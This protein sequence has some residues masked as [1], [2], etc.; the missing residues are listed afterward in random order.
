MAKPSYTAPPNDPPVLGSPNFAA[1]AQGYLGWFPTFGA[2]CEALA[3]W[4]QTEYVAALASGSAALPALAFASDPNTGIFRPGADQLGFSTNGVRRLLLSAAAL[5]VDVPL[6]GIAVTQSNIDTTPGRLATVGW[7]GL[8]AN[9]PPDIPD[10][11][12]ELRPGFYT[13]SE[14]TAV[15]APGNGAAWGGTAIVAR[16]P[17]ASGHTMVIAT[18]MASGA[19]RTWIGVRGGLT[20]ALTWTELYHQRSVVGTVGQSAGV[21]TG[22][23]I[24]RGSNANGEYVRFADG[25]QIC[26]V[27]DVDM[28]SVVAAG[29]GTFADPWRTD[30]VTNITWPA[31]FAAPPAVAPCVRLGGSG[32]VNPTARSLALQVTSSAGTTGWIN[33]RAYRC[34]SDAN[35][36][37]ALLSVTATGRWY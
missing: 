30:A 35:A 20:G 2:Y 5:Q 21:P 15:G 3:S 19:P 34:S 37:N 13:Y 28:G 33:L 7:M 22:A 27:T 36:Q 11:T 32:A 9:S 26:T 23:V 24:E 4:L 25:T 1:N 8:G 31:V 29:A 6:T 17:A 18:R 16:L 12:Q 10:F 14:L